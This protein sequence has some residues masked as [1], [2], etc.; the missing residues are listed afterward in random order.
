MTIGNK[1]RCRLNRLLAAS[2]IAVS[3]VLISQIVA[4]QVILWL[5]TADGTLLMT[6]YTI[7]TRLTPGSA[8]NNAHFSKNGTYTLIGYNCSFLLLHGYIYLDYRSS[9]VQVADLMDVNWN[10]ATVL[11]PLTTAPSGYKALCRNLLDRYF[12]FPGSE[13]FDTKICTRKGTWCICLLLSVDL[14]WIKSNG[15]GQDVLDHC[16]RGTFKRLLYRWTT[17]NSSYYGTAQGVQHLIL[18]V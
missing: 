18:M 10:F 5:T 3:N 7:V 8:S 17:L 6:E 16:S 4:T 9:S 1:F 11:V 12:Y 2:L 13:Y 14:T 15:N